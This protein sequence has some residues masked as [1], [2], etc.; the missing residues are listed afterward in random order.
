MSTGDFNEI[1]KRVG[2]LSAQQRAEL[3]DKLERAQADTAN[4]DPPSESLLDAFQRRGV[5]GS[6]QDEPSD[7]SSNPDHLEGFGNDDQ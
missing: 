2:E 5:V 7:W 4:G 6:I 1:L 3:I